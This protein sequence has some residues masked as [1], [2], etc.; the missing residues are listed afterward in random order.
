MSTHNYSSHI[1]DQGIG[2]GSGSGRPRRS[3][4]PPRPSG[5]TD[6]ES[7][8]D[9]AD[10]EVLD[11]VMK[12]ATSVNMRTPRDRKRCRNR[13]RKSREFPCLLLIPCGTKGWGNVTSETCKVTL[14]LYLKNSY[15]E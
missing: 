6:S 14:V 11:A 8:Y 9:T 15:Q 10:D 5:G 4:A 13:E 7:V 1:P 2:S 3:L 12:S